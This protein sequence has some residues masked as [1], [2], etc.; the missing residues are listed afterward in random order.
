LDA[1][2]VIYLIEQPATWGPRAASYVATL[3]GPKDRIVLSDLSRLECRVKPMAT[4][5]AVL[6]ARYDAFF[7]SAN[8]QIVGLTAQV[9]DRA[10][11]IRATYRYKLG[12]ALNLAAA[13][14]HGCHRFI[15]NDQRLNTYRDIPV[16]MLP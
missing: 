5:N 2:I 3:L 10:T 15:T 9:C 4:G 12:D 13:V 8:V 1:N 6:L 7:G 16:D 11:A 14:T